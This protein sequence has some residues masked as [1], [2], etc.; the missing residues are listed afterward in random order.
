MQVRYSVNFTD[1][2]R[3]VSEL[4]QSACIS[5]GTGVA[6]SS[7]SG[8][9]ALSAIL[10]KPYAILKAMT[11]LGNEK[12]DFAVT[13]AGR[14]SSFANAPAVEFVF[15]LIAHDIWAIL[16]DGDPKLKKDS[17]ML[18]TDYNG[19]V[20]KLPL[21]LLKMQR[22]ILRGFIHAGELG[23]VNSGGTIGMSSKVFS[24]MLVSSFV[25]W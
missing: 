9:P 23:I 15:K 14:K 7:I 20:N 6:K 13:V 2:E 24:D 17:R 3:F 21:G 16:K 5:S 11:Q 1:L 4:E 25:K 22:A 18:S 8:D 19:D 12:P 10:M